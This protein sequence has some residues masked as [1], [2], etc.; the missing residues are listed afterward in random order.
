ML[1]RS[2]GPGW[3]AL[4][5]ALALPATLAAE[6]PFSFADTPGQLPKTAVPRHYALRIQPDLAARTTTGTARI[7]F[8]ALQPVHELVLN[9]LELDITSAVL[10]D[11]PAHP[12]PL[13]TRLDP[14]RQ[15]LTLAAPEGLAAGSHTIALAYRGRIGTQA[16]GI[17]VDQYPTPSGDKLMLGTQM[18]PTDARRVFPCWDEPVYRAT[19]D[20][21]LVVPEKLLAV[22]NM[23]VVRETP[24][25]GGLKEVVFA[26]TPAMASYLVALYAGEFETVEGEQDGVKLRIVTT[27][28]KRPTALYALECTKRILA[29]YNQ[30]FGIRYPLPKLD[31]IAVPNAF[32]SFGAMENWGAITYIDTAILFDPA[33]SSQVR[34][35][36]VFTTIAH[37]MAHQWFGD[38]VTMAWWDNIWLNEG[39]ASWMGTKS[40]AALNPEWQLWLR[41]SAD[42]DRAMDLD[43]RRTTHPIQ[44]PIA[45]ESQAGDAFDVISYQKGQ[46]FL[47]MLEAYLGEDTFRAGI[48]RYIAQHQYSSTTTADL[49]TA[50]GEA[51]GKPVVALAAGWTEQPGFPVVQVSATGTGARRMLELEQQRFTFDDPTAAP[52]TWK[53]PVTVA[54][55]ARL[56]TPAVVLLEDRAVTVPWPAGSGTPKVNIGDTGYYR[57]LY[58]EPFAAALRREIATLP[59]GDQLNLL[60]DTWALVEA[61]RVPAPTW[62]DLAD[63]LGASTSPAVVSQILDRLWA[64]DRLQA[65]EPGRRAYQAWIVKRL[66]P[67]LT[68]LGWTAAPGESP[69]DGSLR[70]DTINLLGQCGDAAVIR[71]CSRRFE[72][73]LQDPAT[74]A[75]DLRAPVLRTVGRYATRETY[76]KLHTLARTALTTEEKRRAYAALQAAEDPALARDTLALSLGHELSVNE[77]VRNVA[78]IAANDHAALAWDFAREHM[79]AL[80]AQVAFFGR[81]FYVPNILRFFND[82]A[83]ADELVDYVRKKLPPDA[84][85]E[86]EKT[87]DGMRHLAAVK[88]RELPAIDA[89][90]K[91]RITAPEN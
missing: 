67:Q 51:S 71:E 14:A 66:A 25:A 91:A 4:A 84:L 17:F 13:A 5:L 49:W 72:A 27:E 16:Q 47:R 21:T 75:G 23:P 90:V 56:A 53:I 60:S 20:V 82:A 55:T 41:A 81:N 2:V 12:R 48:R 64:I 3:R 8:E 78:A 10:L 22:A 38:L 73:Y 44:R 40:S 89:W 39:F 11:D 54:N 46:C 9:A 31:Q 1:P 76:E 52:L 26:R 50:L 70:A 83:R 30:Y 37:E 36:A 69:L 65:G 77:S 32:A 61:G 62:L 34:R 58:D 57:A 80:L 85:A 6:R 15:T 28:G 24:L 79:D 87:A 7:E 42:K 59:V 86:A 29:F 45:N 63:K 88:R 43:A 68:R 18:E 19:Y 74:L 33:A 35:E